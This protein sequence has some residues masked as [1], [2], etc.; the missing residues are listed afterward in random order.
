M[1][2]F[3]SNSLNTKSTPIPVSGSRS[4]ASK[5]RASLQI[6]PLNASTTSISNLM[7]VHF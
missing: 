7:N 2:S 4:G 3:N 5:T 6:T 1:I